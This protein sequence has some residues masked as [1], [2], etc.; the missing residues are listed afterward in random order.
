VP[1]DLPWTKGVVAG[2][3][4]AIP[5]TD[6]RALE[7][8]RGDTAKTLVLVALITAAGLI[9]IAAAMHDCCGAS[10]LGC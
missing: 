9:V 6:V 2:A 10:G 5:L 3:L 1:K 8:R 4:V 7:V